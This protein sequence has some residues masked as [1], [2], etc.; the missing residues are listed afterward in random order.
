MLKALISTVV[1][2]LA[3][4][5]NEAPPPINPFDPIVVGNNTCYMAQ[6]YYPTHE[7]ENILPDRMTIP[8]KDDME[9]LYPDTEIVEGYHPFMLSFCHG[10]YVHDIITKKN[11]PQQEE[12]MFVFPI[13]YDGLHMCSYPPVLYLN[14]S[15]GVAGGIYFGLRKEFHPEMVTNQTN[16]TKEWH[17]KNIID[18]SFVRNPDIK[19][20][21]V[22]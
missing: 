16:T 12:L 11:V 15:E 13:K 22:T 17:I 7:L 6:G 18:G 3:L 2:K 4:D 21:N 20:T 10:A 9:L 5:Y 14:S 19:S 1:S 8:S